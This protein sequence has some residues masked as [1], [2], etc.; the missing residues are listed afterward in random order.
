M[1]TWSDFAASVVIF[2]NN[3]LCSVLVLGQHNS[4]RSGWVEYTDIPGWIQSRIFA[5]SECLAAGLQGLDTCWD[6][7]D[8][9]AVK[10]QLVALAEASPRHLHSCVTSSDFIL[11]SPVGTRCGKEQRQGGMASHLGCEAAALLHDICLEGSRL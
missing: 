4:G 7:F 8:R 11:L 1:G 2:G 5:R 3:L 6:R 10:R 9:A